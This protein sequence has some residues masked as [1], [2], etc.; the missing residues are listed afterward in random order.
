MAFSCKSM[1]SKF[2]FIFYVIIAAV[3]DSD[4]V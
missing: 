4:N 1:E 2:L 3:F